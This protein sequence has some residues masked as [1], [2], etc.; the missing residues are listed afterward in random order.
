MCNQC[1]IKPVYEFTNKRKLCKRCFINYF[2]KKFLYIIRKFK[3]IKT[4]DIIGYENKGNFRGVVLE[5]V[6]NIFSEKS[7][8]NI[9]K[10]PSKKKITRK[11]ISVTLDIDSDKFIHILFKESEKKIKK[12]ISPVDKINN[13]I[14]IKPL[15]L[16]LDKEVL[17]YAKLKNLKFKVLKE[18]QKDKISIFIDELEEKHP[19]LKRAIINTYL[20]LY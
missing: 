6:L 20:E 19:E 12:D 15:Y 17:L 14:I 10:L 3:M 11:A 1:E 8:I 2:N 13:V 5:E 9:I 16:F 18:K 7:M 4:D